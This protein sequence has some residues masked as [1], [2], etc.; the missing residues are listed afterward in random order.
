M[1]SS[2]KTE[3]G[4]FKPEF[5]ICGDSDPVRAQLETML[6]EN[7]EHRYAG[8]YQAA[9]AAVTQRTGIGRPGALA[10]CKTAS[11]FTRMVEQGFT[12]AGGVL[13]SR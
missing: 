3:L 10:L 7:L 4:H 5:R 2:L 8:A 13:T 9:R 6:A 1:H 11:G 12:K